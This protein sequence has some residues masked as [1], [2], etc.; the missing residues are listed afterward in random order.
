MKATLN[1]TVNDTTS[2][3]IK[4][5][6]IQV[7]KQEITLDL[8]DKVTDTITAAAMPIE[9]A[10]RLLIYSIEPATLAS[11]NN[12]GEITAKKHR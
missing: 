5:S 6:D 11:I 9:A 4:V 2:E 10:N 3:V 7:D 12:I 1:V 8:T